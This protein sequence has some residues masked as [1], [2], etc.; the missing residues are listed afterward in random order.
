MSLQAVSDKKEK[1]L[2]EQIIVVL[3]FSIMMAWFISIFFK[4]EQQISEAGF[5]TLV[6][7]FS[8]KL[9][10]IRSQWLMDQKPDVVRVKSLGIQNVNQE[11]EVILTPVNDRGWVDISHEPLA[12]EKIWN[13][14]MNMPLHFMKSPISAIEIKKSA[15]IDQKLCRY[16]T[17]NGNYFE[18][19]P[20]AGKVLKG[21]SGSK[22]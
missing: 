5:K 12:C 1:S 21:E 15:S 14:V 7:T 13:L 20:A 19:Y 16:S 11:Q 22:K 18:Y 4:Q 17:A 2:A 6:N 3:L 8:A 10:S 9:V